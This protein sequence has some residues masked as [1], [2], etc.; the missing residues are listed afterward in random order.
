MK[1][2]FKAVGTAVALALAAASA[3]AQLT[4]APG[5][6]TGTP[7]TTGTTPVVGQP[8]VLSIFDPTDAN[9]V[10]VNLVYNFATATGG[11]VTAGGNFTPNSAGG[12]FTLAADPL[13]AS[14]QVL[15]LNFGTI[16]GLPSG[17]LSSSTLFWVSGFN[18]VSG[19]VGSS[20][21]LLVTQPLTNTLTATNANIT[22]ADTAAGHWFPDWGSTGVNADTGASAAITDL[23]NTGNSNWTE[24][25]GTGFESQL[26]GTTIGNALNM[27]EVTKNGVLAGH[28]ATVTEVG[29]AQGAGF[30][31][32]NSNDQLTWNV[33]APPSAVPLPAAGWLLL[34]GLAG[35]GAVARRRRAGEVA[36]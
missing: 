31:F 8:F 26:T 16:P 12:E 1:L 2:N 30:W 22:G 7:P 34:S 24:A 5:Y 32:I 25:L 17:G 36:A 33:L 14:L 9:S 18:S 21:S 19:G 3:H 27:Y 11:G 28:A 20:T 29:N 6:N 15:Q 4:T 23:N 10:A 13:N 35:L